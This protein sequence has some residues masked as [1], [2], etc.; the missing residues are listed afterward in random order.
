M[1]NSLIRKYVLTLCLALLIVAAPSLAQGGSRARFVN[2]APGTPAIDIFVNGELVETGLAFGE[3]TL[4]S[5]FLQEI[6]LC[7]A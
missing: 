5:T 7:S 1:K 4:T 2:V 3:S 6:W